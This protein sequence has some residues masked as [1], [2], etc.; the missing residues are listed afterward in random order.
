MWLDHTFA[1][2]VLHSLAVCI[3]EEYLEEDE[4]WETRTSESCSKNKTEHTM[5]CKLEE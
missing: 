5:F 2:D 3:A 1:S 4:W